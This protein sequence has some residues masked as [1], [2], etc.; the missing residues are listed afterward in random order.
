MGTRAKILGIYGLLLATGIAISSQIFFSGRAIQQTTDGLLSSNVPLLADIGVIKSSL[1]EYERSQYEYYATTDRD[2][3]LRQ[4][5]SNYPRLKAAQKHI[6]TLIP[7]EARLALVSNHIDSMVT[8]SSELDAV[9]SPR[10]VNWDK[11]RQLLEDITSA[12]QR[13]LPLLNDLER[14][15]QAALLSTSDLVSAS[16]GVTAKMV[17]AFC[18]LVVIVAGLVGYY[19]ERFV[20]LAAERRFLAYYDPLTSLPSAR[21]TESL[22]P[23]IFTR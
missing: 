22:T 16:T 18:F 21:L 23:N 12:N 6:A 9:L 13:V 20:R 5:A 14:E 7:N 3:M 8:L 11:A 1:I 19:L 17:F 2:A 10:Q 4:H 15:S